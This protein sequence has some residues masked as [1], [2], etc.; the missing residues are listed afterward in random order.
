M[1]LGS[2]FGDHACSGKSASYP[3][4]IRKMLIELEGRNARVYPRRD[5]ISADKTLAQV[6]GDKS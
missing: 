4:D 3:D 6:I 2:P 1:L 5:L